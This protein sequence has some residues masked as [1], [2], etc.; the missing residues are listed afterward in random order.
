MSYRISLGGWLITIIGNRLNKEEMMKNKIIK[1]QCKDCRYYREIKLKPTDYISL[2]VANIEIGYCIE[3]DCKVNPDN[4]D[5]LI[6]QS[7]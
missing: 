7:N 1:K 5:C 4:S 3:M 6:K 2:K